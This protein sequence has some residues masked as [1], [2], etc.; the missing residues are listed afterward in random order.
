MTSQH[1]VT[2]VL[3]LLGAATLALGGVFLRLWKG[4]N[5]ARQERHSRIMGEHTQT[6][7][8]HSERIDTLDERMRD[9][10]GHGERLASLEVKVDFI[11]DDTGSMKIAV[12]ELLRRARANGGK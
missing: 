7:A 4:F 1:I 12:D 10:R 9:T 11:R 3:S 6:L 8:S 2:F 5:P